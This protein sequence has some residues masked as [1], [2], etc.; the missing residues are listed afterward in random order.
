[1]PRYRT[2]QYRKCLGALHDGSQED[3]HDREI[4]IQSLTSKWQ[5]CASGCERRDCAFDDQ[6]GRT[7]SREVDKWWRVVMLRRTLNDD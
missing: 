7:D 6:M 3:E 5:A 4:G 2:F 1:V